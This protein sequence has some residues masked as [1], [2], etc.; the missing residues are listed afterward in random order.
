M[1]R[2]LNFCGAMDKA[3]RSA[4]PSAGHVL[5][6]QRVR[7]SFSRAAEHYD[8]LAVLQRQVGEGLLERLAK[9]PVDPAML[10]DMGAGTGF[11]AARLADRYPDARVIAL[12]IS[13]SMLHR[14]RGRD[15]LARRGSFIC[16]DAESLPLPGESV[17]VIFSNLTLQ[18]C[19]NLDSV[20][21]EFKR[22]LREGGC[23]LFSSFGPKTLRELRHA[24]QRADGHSHV[25]EFAARPEIA[26][27]MKRAGLARL[28]LES[29]L[30]AV[31][32]PSVYRLMRELKGIGAHNVTPDRPRHLTG[33]RTLQRMI[34][35]YESLMENGRIRASFEVI[36][37]LASKNGSG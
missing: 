2:A 25:N 11:F 27:A 17:E 12:D 19:S 1:L 21:A 15:S 34:E 8:G 24:W 20:F 31:D 36:Y 6:K 22:V 37:G 29:A 5:D 33:K 26:A 9:L 14:A 18:W 35:A 10:L 7:R 28:A 4:M 3:D 32:Y 30:S 13:E 23:M 16:G